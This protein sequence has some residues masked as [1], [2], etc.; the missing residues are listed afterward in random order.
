MA[1]YLKVFWKFYL[2]TWIK[3]I[4]YSLICVSMELDSYVLF[5]VVITTVVH[6][7]FLLPFLLDA[8]YSF[9]SLISLRFGV[10]VWLALSIEMWVQVLHHFWLKPL[11]TDWPQPWYLGSPCWDEASIGSLRNYREQSFSAELHG[12]C[13]WMR[14]QCVLVATTKPILSKV[15]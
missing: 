15:V 5:R 8:W 7:M 14:R 2:L 3:K 4:N 6:H 13:V 9:T 1:P 10:T 11:K 12:T